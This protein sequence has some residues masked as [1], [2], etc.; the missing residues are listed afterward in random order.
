MKNFRFYCSSCKRTIP[1]LRELLKGQGDDLTNKNIVK[2]DSKKINRE[3]VAVENFDGVLHYMCANI[4]RSIKLT[5]SSKE[6]LAQLF[7]EHNTRYR[8][9]Y[10]YYVWVVEFDGEIFNI[11]TAKGRGMEFSIVAKYDSKKR[12]EKSRVCIN[13]LR[14]MEELLDGVHN[15]D[16]K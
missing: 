14:K 16:A 8:G 10:F 3:S 4:K 15:A 13:F 2:T 6:K 1:K 11:F 12:D 9:N 5:S 7:G